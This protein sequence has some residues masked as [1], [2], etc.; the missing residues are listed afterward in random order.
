ML[1]TLPSQA[2]SRQKEPFIRLIGHSGI[3]AALSL[4]ECFDKCDADGDKCAAACFTPQYKSTN[5]PLCLAFKFGFEQKID[6][7]EWTAYIKPAVVAELTASDFAATLNNTS[8][9]LMPNT[10]FLNHYNSLDTLTPSQC[11]A[12]C[13]ES[14]SCAAASF[15]AD[16]R[17]LNNCYFFTSDEVQVSDER[18]AIET[19]TSYVK[20]SLGSDLAGAVMPHKSILESA[21]SAISTSTVLANTRLY[22]HFARYKAVNSRDC[23]DK[24][25]ADFKCAAACFTLPSACRLYKYGFERVAGVSDS[26]AY[27]KEKVSRAMSESELSAAYPVVVRARKLVG[28]NMYNFDTLTP[29]Q[30]FRACKVSKV[31][32]AAAF[33]AEIHEL[34]NCYLFKSDGFKQKVTSVESEYWTA[35]MKSGETAPATS[36]DPSTVSQ[37]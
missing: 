30:C 28:E 8:E 21:T 36:Q 17:W 26:T 16:A 22:N 2:A 12:K 9:N 31:C 20:T 4:D 6:T 19:W 10:R 34:Y 13:K 7:D 14:Y 3:Y 25:D 29:E 5:K 1:L 24:C 23:F 37:N 15:T 18:D 27:V 11:F 32:G 35:Y 33:T